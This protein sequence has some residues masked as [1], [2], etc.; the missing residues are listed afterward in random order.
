[1]TTRRVAKEEL[2]EFARDESERENR[3]DLAPLVWILVWAAVGGAIWAVGAL[4]LVGAIG[5]LL[6]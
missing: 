5:R 1:M 6:S 3:N 4:A 2:G